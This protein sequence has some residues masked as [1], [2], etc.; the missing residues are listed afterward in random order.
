MTRGMQRLVPV[1]LVVIAVGGSTHLEAAEPT[2]PATARTSG[3]ERSPYDL[4]PVEVTS[5]NGMVVSGS[6]QASK[7][8]AAILEAGGNA[9]DAAVATAFALGVTEP[10]TSGLGAETFILIY[11]ADGQAHAIDGSCY[12]PRLARP[13]ELQ[14]VRAAADRGYFQGYKSIT[15]P[16]SLAALAYAIERHGT[17]SLAEVLA[18]AIDLADFGFTFTATSDSEI[19]APGRVP[20]DP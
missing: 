14:G 1:L 2:P 20:A 6:E 13:A 18:P 11:G 7:A 5:V 4:W 16:G 10:M 8:G 19:A 9:V 3:Y 15:V 17:K 12:V